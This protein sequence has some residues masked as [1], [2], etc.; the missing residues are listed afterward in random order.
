MAPAD[1]ACPGGERRPGKIV[2]MSNVT[3]DVI[4][5]TALEFIPAFAF[6]LWAEPVARAIGR[7]PSAVRIAAP[8]LLA[9]PYTILSG[10]H[11][12]FRW[13]WFV[14]Y[15]TLPMAMAWLLRQLLQDQGGAQS[16]KEAH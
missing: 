11:H 3:P 5:I 14:L 2:T 10:L 8:A 9:I 4:A 15:C 13:E 1:R 12:I 7:W 16:T 6:A